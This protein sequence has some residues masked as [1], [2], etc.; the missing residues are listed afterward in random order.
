MMGL[1][2]ILVP[3]RRYISPGNC[4]SPA[5][6]IQHLTAPVTS[7]TNPVPS[8]PSPREEAAAERQRIR[9]EA[10]Q[11]LLVAMANRPGDIINRDERVSMRDGRLYREVNQRLLPW[12][13]EAPTEILLDF[14]DDL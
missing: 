8:I 4:F 1:R 10:E 6:H 7:S 12:V 14:E 5:P 9:A 2:P 13:N 11:G 3:N